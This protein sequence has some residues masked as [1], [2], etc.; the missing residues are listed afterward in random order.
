[1]SK[2]TTFTLLLASLSLVAFILH[3]VLERDQKPPVRKVEPGLA[4][5]AK[6]SAIH[7]EEKTELSPRM[8]AVRASEDERTEQIYAR[9]EREA[10]FNMDDYGNHEAYLLE[11]HKDVFDKWEVPSSKRRTVVAVLNEFGREAFRAFR[12]SALS[13][14][15]EVGHASNSTAS[16]KHDA[17]LLRRVRLLQQERNR[18]IEEAVGK[19]V[20]RDLLSND[21]PQRK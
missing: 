10:K 2:K 21:S 14:P 8:L 16:T 6:R 17:E 11:K 1:M 3:Y 20:A 19:K 15:T 4:A 18:L 12:D 7:K 9:I 5:P 13:W